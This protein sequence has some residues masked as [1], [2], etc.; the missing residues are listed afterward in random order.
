MEME[1][2]KDIDNEIWLLVLVVIY[3]AKLGIIAMQLPF[4]RPN[5]QKPN[6]CH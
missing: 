2:M 4:K 6:R 3:A 5:L 1:G